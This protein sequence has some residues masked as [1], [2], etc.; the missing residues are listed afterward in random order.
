MPLLR[1]G[2]PLPVLGIDFSKPA[3]FLDP[4][5]GF[6]QNM[7]YW[8]NTLRKRAG[9]SNVGSVVADSTQIMGL[10]TLDLGAQ[11]IKYTIRNSKAKMEKFDTGTNDWVSIAITDFTGGDE[12]FFSYATVTESGLL[13]I[14]NFIDAIRKWNGAGNASALGGT[15]GRAKYMTYLSPY[16]LLAYV[17]EA[18]NINPWK[19]KWCDTDN[20]EVWSGGNAGSALLSS[21]PSP[22]QNIKKLNDFVVGYKK[23]SLWL[24]RKVDPPD[25]FQFDMIKTGIGLAAPRALAEAEGLH[26]FMGQNDFFS[27]NGIRENPIGG[28]VREQVFDLIDRSKIN[29]CFAEHVQEETEI[30]FYIVYSGYNW[31]RNVWKY[32]YRTGYWYYDTCDEMT[33]ALKWERINT[34]SW[35]AT[36]GTWNQQQQSWDSGIL[37]AAW[38]EILLGRSNGY[39]GKLDYTTTDDFGVAVDS[40]FPTKDFTSERGMEFDERW[41]QL[42]VWAR[43]V[44]NLYVDYSVDEGV[45]WTNIPYTS[46]Q[47]YIDMDGTMRKYEMWLDVMSPKI[48]FRFRCPGSRETWYLQQFI[49][50][51]LGNE[52]ETRTFR[53]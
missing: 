9:K 39:V 47:A 46:S 51:Y 28:P 42:D 18:G 44:G 40:Q 13:I 4:R 21:E 5:A 30:H 17:N 49:P 14:S 29:R 22:I 11:S 32:N 31:P 2:V 26:Y 7:R 50:Y 27:W 53:Q 10:G 15:P 41:L 45:T 8:R 37:V 12:D 48:R 19:V 1:K 3:S 52:A 36:S 35:D 43:G 20:P 34:Q 25:I 24:G 6:P 33:A 38:E 23:D 16:L